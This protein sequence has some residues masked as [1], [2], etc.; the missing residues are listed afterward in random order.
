MTLSYKKKIKIEDLTANKNPLVVSPLQSE[1]LRV[2]IQSSLLENRESLKA[3]MGEMLEFVKEHASN[4]VDKVTKAEEQDIN[5][6]KRDTIESN[7]QSKQQQSKEEFVIS[8]VGE[9]Y[10]FSKKTLSEDINI[11][12]RWVEGDEIKIPIRYEKNICE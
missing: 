4:I 10:S 11:E 5:S 1:K 2:I 7:F 3:K 6:F 9:K 8:V 12:K